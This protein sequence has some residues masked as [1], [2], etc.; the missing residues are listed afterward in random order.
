[1]SGA[2]N[3]LCST[4]EVVE[5]SVYENVKSAIST[6]IDTTEVVE[7]SFIVNVKICENC[8]NCFW[9]MYTDVSV[10]PGVCWHTAATRGWGSLVRALLNSNRVQWNLKTAI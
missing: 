1:M 8:G 5:Y 9:H 3:V 4:A 10:D 7:V 2:L 6:E